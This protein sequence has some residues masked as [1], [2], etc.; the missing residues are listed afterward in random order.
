[1]AQYRSAADNEC[2]N[3]RVGRS[4]LGVIV[5]T[6]YLSQIPWKHLGSSPLRTQCKVRGTGGQRRGD[7]PREKQEVS[8][9]QIRPATM[10]ARKHKSVHYNNPDTVDATPNN[11]QQHPL[12]VQINKPIRRMRMGHCGTVVITSTRRYLIE[13]YLL[14]PTADEHTGCLPCLTLHSYTL[15]SVGSRC[16][17]IGSYRDD[18]QVGGQQ[19]INDHATFDDIL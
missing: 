7:S 11:S 17:L 8:T 10:P 9:R 19:L 14:P 3:E 16:G 2:S 6:L 18:R 13:E 15:G 12:L 1:M 5:L 4:V